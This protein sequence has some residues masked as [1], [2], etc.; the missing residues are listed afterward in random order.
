[1]IIYPFVSIV[2][3]SLILSI[4]I[5]PLH[6]ILTNKIGG[7]P[8]LASFI[9][10]S[11][12]LAIFIL[13]SVFILGSL[14]DEIKELKLSY[15]NG[16]LTIPPPT[17]KVKEWPVIGENTYNTWQSISTNLEQTIINNK[18]HL[19]EFS[20][21]IFSGVLGA[22]GGLFQMMA[23]LIIA[24]ILLVFGRT[25]EGIRKFFRK[26][27]VDKGDEFT[28]VT[29]KTVNNVVKGILG[30]ALIVALLHGLIFLFAGIP[31]TGVWT[32]LVLILA[33]LQIPVVLVSLP[34]VIHLF[35]VQDTGTAI[36]FTILLILAG[37]S[38][39]IL[40]PIL[41]GKGAP[42]PMLVIFIGVIG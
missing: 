3:W 22:V 30:V 23:S 26:V 20:S 11:S 29:L 2:L 17:D 40:R 28:D 16:T 18:E 10:V 35:A 12:I 8:K 33:V 6:Q 19:I 32:L 7:R 34:I 13:P 21:Q 31:F 25:F 41:L 1:M 38:D 36:I 37:L 15:D 14:I 42:V 27:A 24:G 9:I 4:A 39:N 5:Y